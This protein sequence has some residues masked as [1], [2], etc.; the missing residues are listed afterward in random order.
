MT[1]CRVNAND[2]VTYCTTLHDKLENKKVSVTLFI[3]SCG[4]GGLVG[5]SG[6]TGNDGTDPLLR[7]FITTDNKAAAA[8][9]S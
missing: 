8:A 2:Q 6:D 7:H 5:T 1:S 4:V 9:I 3:K